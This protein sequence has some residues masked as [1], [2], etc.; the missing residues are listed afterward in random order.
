MVLIDS[1]VQSIT[2]LLLDP[3]TDMSQQY[4]I[5]RSLHSD[6]CYLFTM[7]VGRGVGDDIVVED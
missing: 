2:R 5:G 4:Q 3:R 6:L 1:L 7:V